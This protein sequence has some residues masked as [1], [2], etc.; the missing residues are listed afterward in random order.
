MKKTFCTFLLAALCLGAQDPKPAEKPAEPE[1]AEEPIVFRSDVALARVDAQVLERGGS[2]AITGL[3][4]EDFV[5][6]DR[7]QIRDI[8]NFANDDMPVDII[9]LLDV[10]RSMMPHVS[11]LARAS[12]QALGS[13]GDDDRVAVMVFDR[14]SRVHSQF[15]KGRNAIASELERV[16]DREH[17]NGGTDITR[18]LVDAAN[19]M[20]KNGRKDVRRAIVI[21]TDDRT[22]FDRNEKRVLNALYEADAG[23]SALIAP[24][25]H[26]QIYGPT[27][28]GS[29]GGGGY[30]GGGGGYPGGGGGIGFPGGGVGG[31]LGGVILGR[32][33]GGGGYPGG[34]YPGGGYP[35]GGGGS[36]PVV[37]GGGGLQSAGTSEIARE[38]GGDSMSVYDASA[39]QDTLDRIRQKYALYFNAAADADSPAISVELSEAARRRYPSA[40]VRARRSYAGGGTTAAPVITTGPNGTIDAPATTSDARSTTGTESAEES[41]PRMRRRPVDQP[42]DSSNRGPA[43]LPAPT[44]SQDDSGSRSNGGWRRIDEPGSKAGPLALPDP[45]RKTGSGTVSEPV[46]T[47]PPAPAAKPGGWRRATP[48]DVNPPVVEASPTSKKN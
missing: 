47:T 16:I 36:G 45:N 44:V 4:P 2:R 8:K 25:Q 22:E 26:G 33:R 27:T 39:F 24:D 6:R 48:E 19:Y 21:L 15:I 1:Q 40:I 29:T 13:L 31:P 35:G 38:S 34:G 41:R 42:D 32:R 9:I 43:T 18:A 14:S 11:S 23:L 12:R 7:G 5:I 10:S 30:P 46:P 37:F 3:R 28:G 20:R 17:F